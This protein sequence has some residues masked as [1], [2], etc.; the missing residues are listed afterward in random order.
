MTDHAKYPN[1][2]KT[3][4]F[5]AALRGDPKK[6]ARAHEL[7]AMERELKQARAAFDLEE[8]KE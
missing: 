6:L 8:V 4:D 2:P 5:L 3:H 7:L 1:R